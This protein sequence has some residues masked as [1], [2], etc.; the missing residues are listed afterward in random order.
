MMPIEPRD[1]ATTRLA[2]V[3]PE[4]R[5]RSRMQAAIARICT[6]IIAHRIKVLTAIALITALCAMQIGN[7]R[8]VIDPNTM[9]PQHHP[10][11]IGTLTAERLFGSKHVVVVGISAA[12]GGTVYDDLDVLAAVDRLTR[13][14]SA[15]PGVKQ[16]TMMSLTAEKAKAISGDDVEM[17]VE[18]MLASPVD[19]DAARGLRARLDGNPIYRGTLVSAD[20]K[21]AS[22][23]FAISA[24]KRGFREIVDPVLAV[25]EAER[26]TGLRIDVSGTAV[27]IAAVE[28]FAQRMLLLFPLALLIIGLIHF[29]AFRTLQ[30]LILPL[31]TALLAVIWGL[32]IMGASG[33]PMDAF[34][35]TT[36]ILILAVAAGHAVQILKRYYEEYDRAT[37]ARPDVGRAALNDIAIVESLAKV[38]PV[39]LTAGLVATLGFFSLITFDVA[40]IRTFGIFTGLGIISAMMIELTF[41]PALRSLL[42][43]PPPA[44]QKAKAAPLWRRFADALTNLVLRRNKTVLVG[45]LALAVLSSIGLAFVERENSTKSYFADDLDIRAED[46]FLNKHLAGTNTLY[47]VFQGDRVDQMKDPKVL[48]LIERTQRH[49]EALPNVGKTLSIV[50][51]L[52]R[53]NRSI[54]GG[55]RE[56]DALPASQEMVSQYLLLYSMSGQPTDFDPYIDYDYKNANLIVWMKSDSS[57]YA[58]SVVANIRAF[59]Q[60]QLPKGVTVQIGGSV[61]Q[62]SALSETLVEGKIRNILQMMLVVLVAGAVIFRSLAAGLYLAAPL[63]LTVLV[64]FGVMGLT[65]IPL[66]T[67][68][69]V[70]SAMAIGI[71]A[72]YAIY[73]LYRFREEYAELGDF[74]LAMRETMQTAGKAIVYVASAIAGGYSVLLFSFGFYVHIWFGILIVMSMIVSAASA[75]LLIP[76]LLKTFTPAFALGGGRAPSRAVLASTAALLLTATLVVH[77]PV[78]AASLDAQTVMTRNY[79][80]TRFADSRSEATFRLISSGGQERVRKTL[81]VTKMQADGVQNRRM[82]RFLSPSDVRNT[83]TLLIENSGKDDEIWV[84]LPATKKARRLAANNKR[85]SF[86]GTDL[87]YGDIVGHR[88]DSWTHVM[89]PET[90]IAGKAVYVIESKPANAKV[91]SDSGYSKRVSWIAKDSFVA[92][93]VD[94]YDAAGA[95]L[96]TLENSDLR[97]IDAA[98]GKWQPMSLKVRNHQTGHTTM[99][100]VDSFK[101]N[102]GVGD[103]F[104]SARYL[105]KEQ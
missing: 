79:Q 46:R 61:P 67:P 81:G 30:G 58:G 50:D 31:V 26:K 54:N 7:L 101:T 48:A 1:P 52:K 5:P 35:A 37:Q 56:F 32:G 42:P 93:K 11:V 55:G 3:P 80:A 23:S 95:L 12:D 87:S 82:I 92:L 62:S 63:L 40:T 16:H 4:G 15:V 72:D 89:Q 83:A 47:V 94:F 76:A 2:T 70:N 36:P 17:R 10:N 45:F 53:M 44:V 27:F 41:I 85:S 59:V 9:L 8:I 19:A 65:G 21:V 24:G 69:S 91:G 97:Q 75:L 22:V 105:E 104:F 14:L 38:A 86:I 39:M 13:T 57:R 29:E 43:A 99:V 96:K 34:N 78:E 20:G 66:N 25:I 28:R 98:Q 33:V 74:D 73:L 102:T 90:T 100:K 88:P 84:Y 18:P 71:G 51:L 103:E 77:A 60:P 68:N 6:V 64:N 49:I